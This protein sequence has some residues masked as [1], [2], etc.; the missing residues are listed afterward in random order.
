MRYR[1]II[2]GIIPA[3]GYWITP[4]GVI[5]PVHKDHEIVSQEH[6]LSTDD[7]LRTGWARIVAGD[8]YKNGEFCVDYV[9]G[10]LT[11]KSIS[12]IRRLARDIG[13]KEFTIHHHGFPGLMTFDRISP[14]L[15]TLSENN[16]VNEFYST[17]IEDYTTG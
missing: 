10:S 9:K 7:A 11:R 5:F 15:L 1:E 2:E 4:D 14:F 6:G 12:S 17:V 3:Y 8:Y 13:P 16:I